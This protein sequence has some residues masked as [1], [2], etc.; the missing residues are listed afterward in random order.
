MDEQQ[1]DGALGGSLLV[2]IMH[3]QVTEPVHGERVQVTLVRV[4]VVP[5]IPSAG[6]LPDVGT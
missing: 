1:R 3:T 2:H 5:L 6:E 4:P